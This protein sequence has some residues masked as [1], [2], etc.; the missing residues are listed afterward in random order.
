MNIYIYVGAQADPWLISTIYKVP[1][2]AQINILMSED[3][4]FADAEGSAYLTNLVS[5]IN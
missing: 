2:F 4:I 5:L 3:E 1:E